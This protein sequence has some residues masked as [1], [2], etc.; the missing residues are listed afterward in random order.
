M[1]KEDLSDL[2]FTKEAKTNAINAAK[3]HAAAHVRRR[4]GFIAGMYSKGERNA[5]LLEKR[6][7]LCAQY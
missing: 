3:R 1:A 4:S 7:Q 5:R 2:G 6:E